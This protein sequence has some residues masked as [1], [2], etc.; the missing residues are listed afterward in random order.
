[1]EIKNKQKIFYTFGMIKP[2]G[3]PHMKEIIQ[4]IYD[5]GLE[6]HYVK[7]KMLTD[8]LIEKNYSHVMEKYPE[9]FKLLK[10]SLKSGPV[11]MMLIFDPKGDAINNYREILGV[12]KSWEAGPNTIRG[13]FGDRKKVYK[14]VAHGSGNPKEAGDE[15]IRFFGDEIL[16]LLEWIRADASYRSIYKCN[17]KYDDLDKAAIT[18]N[19]ANC[20]LK[21]L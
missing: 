9:D 19:D 20:S 4:L 6:I 11:L 1:M 16:W 15:I 10:E 5:N 2:D 13:K 8:E 3:M 12:T 7:A 14:N 17:G 18:I 21:L